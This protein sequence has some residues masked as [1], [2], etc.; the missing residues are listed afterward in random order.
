MCFYKLPVTPNATG[1]ASEFN[2]QFKPEVISEI[3]DPFR[4]DWIQE[5][6][7]CQDFLVGEKES[8][9]FVYSMQAD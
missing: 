7:D 5:P 1:I 4:V 9:A 8:V 3:N 6:V 2:E